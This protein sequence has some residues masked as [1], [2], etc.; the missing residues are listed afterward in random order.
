MSAVSGGVRPR[1]RDQADPRALMSVRTDP[2]RGAGEGARSHSSGP[3]TDHRLSR[4]N[5]PRLWGEAQQ[6]G[7]GSGVGALAVVRVVALAILALA[8]ALS[9]G[10]PLPSGRFR[11]L[12]RVGRLRRLP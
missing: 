4:A 11:W 7:R 12:G 3:G 1:P 8:G 10:F 6:L 5:S 9:H 2:G